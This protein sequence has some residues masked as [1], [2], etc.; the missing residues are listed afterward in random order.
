MCSLPLLKSIGE[1]QAFIFNLE[2]FLVGLFGVKGC[3]EARFAEEE[4]QLVD[5]V[6]FGRERF[7]G[8]DR[9]IRRDNGQLTVCGNLCDEEIGDLAA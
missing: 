3:D 6:E 8:I 4:V 7:V 5:L 1:F 2:G 9:E